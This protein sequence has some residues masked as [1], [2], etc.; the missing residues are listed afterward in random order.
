MDKE[1]IA[2]I[3]G[4]YEQK[5]ILPLFGAGRLSDKLVQGLESILSGEP[6]NLQIAPET[7]CLDPFSLTKTGD[8]SFYA[9]GIRVIYQIGEPAYACGNVDSGTGRLLVYFLS[10][11]GKIIYVPE[12]EP[13]CKSTSFRWAIGH[14]MRLVNSG[15]QTFRLIKVSD[16]PE[17]YKL[18]KKAK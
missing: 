10:N 16:L 15:S 8:I 4:A 14:L 7:T 6:I 9:K 11:A 3:V 12:V 13:I 5:V 1:Q 2:Q 17:A 18:E